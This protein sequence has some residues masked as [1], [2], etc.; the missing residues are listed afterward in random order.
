MPLSLGEAGCFSDR[1][2]WRIPM[3]YA[4]FQQEKLKKS[5]KTVSAKYG[6]YE[7]ATIDSVE[8]KKF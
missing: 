5:K 7:Y 3:M 8:H 4:K 6:D 1:N 2:S